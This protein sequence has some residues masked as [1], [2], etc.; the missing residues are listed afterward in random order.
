MIRLRIGAALAAL[1]LAGPAL[2]SKPAFAGTVDLNHASV[3]ELMKVPGLGR[4]KAEAI[5]ALRAKQPFQK[6]ED[7]MKV[8]GLGKKW[9]A[10][11][12]GHLTASARG[13]NLPR[14]PATK[15]SGAAG[16]HR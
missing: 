2:A 15:P 6:P 8:K 12:K 4:H 16:S 13:A 1:A 3:A 7:V 14:R 11:V 9:F 10:K 5:A